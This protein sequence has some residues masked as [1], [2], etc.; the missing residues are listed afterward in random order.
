MIWLSTVQ[1]SL[2]ALLD[3]AGRGVSY[4]GNQVIDALDSRQPLYNSLGSLALE[5]PVYLPFHGH[6][7]SGHS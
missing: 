6:N 2:D 4:D 5:V 1:R 7:S 3:V